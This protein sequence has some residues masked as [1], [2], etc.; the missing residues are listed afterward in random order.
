MSVSKFLDNSVQTHF[1]NVPHPG[2]QLQLKAAIC[3]CRDSLCSYCC[4]QS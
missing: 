3:I 2:L 1:Q 4:Q